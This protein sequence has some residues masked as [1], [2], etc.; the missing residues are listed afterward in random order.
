MSCT[1]VPSEASQSLTLPSSLPLASRLPSGEKAR[2]HVSFV[3]Q[4][5]Q[6]KAPLSTSQS[7][8]LPSSLPLASVCSSGLKAKANV[9]LVWACQARCRRLPSSRHTRIS[10]RLLRAAQYRPL[11]LMAT[12]EMAS[13]VSVKT[14]SHI[15]APDSVVPCI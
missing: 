5:D 9:V 1:G 3:C 4:C 11:L 12:A 10:P 6:S 7:L 15:T 14:H 8:M 13:K 2:H